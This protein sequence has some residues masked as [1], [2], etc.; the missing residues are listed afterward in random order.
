MDFKPAPDVAQLIIEEIL[1]GLDI[2]KYIDDIGI[3]S[4]TW[5]EHI[6]KI[7]KVLLR[8][9]EAGCKVN[10]LKCEWGIKETDFLGHW[11]TPEGVKPWAKKVDAVLR[12]LAPQDQTQL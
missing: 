10:P 1:A 12:M 4:E 3:F 5:E 11:L 2:K 6:K 7:E 8:L 9:Q